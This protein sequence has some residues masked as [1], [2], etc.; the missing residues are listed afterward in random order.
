MDFDT[1]KA[2]VQRIAAEEAV[3][4]AEDEARAARKAL[5]AAEAKLREL[6]RQKYAAEA[7]ALKEKAS[8]GDA[9]AQCKLGVMYEFGRGVTKDYLEA[10]KWYR[11][12]A[13]QGNILG[14]LG[15]KKLKSLLSA[16]SRYKDKE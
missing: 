16:C 1:I 15:M 10:V 2:K 7:E 11:K 8:N 3:R 5:A 6:E 14:K 4:K 12:S 13:E 9:D